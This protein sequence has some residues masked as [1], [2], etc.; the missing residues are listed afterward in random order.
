MTAFLFL[1]LSLVAVEVKAEEQFRIP[2]LVPITGFLSLEGGSQRD[3]AL[4]ALETHPLSVRLEPQVIDT[5]TSPEKA[6]IAFQRSLEPEKPIA[7]AASIFGPQMLALLPLGDRHRIPMITISGTAAVTEQ[8][9]EYVFRFFPSDP[10]AKYAH[11]L[12]V[13]QEIGAKRVALITQTTA[14]GQ[15]GRQHLRD[16]LTRLNVAIVS[17]ET[18]SPTLRNPFPILNR[19]LSQDPDVLVLHLHAQSTALMIRQAK[20]SGVTIPIVSGSAMH[21][22]S[23]ANLLDPTELE[24]VC[25]ETA[26]S[27]ISQETEA[28]RTFVERYRERFPASAGRL[29][30]GSVRRLVDGLERP[31]VRRSDGGRA[32]FMVRNSFS[33]RRGHEIPL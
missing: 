3:G 5:G 2:I 23:T 19:A 32:P 29:R 8:G 22:P 28:I 18:V 24:G 16:N 33:S 26:S 9:S 31:S 7:I 14:Y 11:A 25:A 30:P 4:L 20:A 12:Y 21:Q 17:D 1:L 27:P 15:S 6:R 10:V 13:A